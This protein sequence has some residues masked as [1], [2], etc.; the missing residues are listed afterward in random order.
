MREGG[1]GAETESEA[2]SEA[3]ICGPQTLSHADQ[4]ICPLHSYPSFS[5]V[6]STVQVVLCIIESLRSAILIDQI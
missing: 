5:L 6:L 4:R 3:V 2:F 1:S